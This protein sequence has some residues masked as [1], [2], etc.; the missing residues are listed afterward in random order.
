MKS[1]NKPSNHADQNHQIQSGFFV[2]GCVRTAQ[3]MAVVDEIVDAVRWACQPTDNG[4]K[5]IAPGHVAVVFTP[6]G[7][8]EKILGLISAPSMS[9]QW[10]YHTYSGH[11]N[12]AHVWHLSILDE[13]DLWG[14]GFQIG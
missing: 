14:A 11:L 3:D 4:P 5:A 13:L 8:V 2:H 6:K 9:S 12:Q 7:A 10:S 1:S